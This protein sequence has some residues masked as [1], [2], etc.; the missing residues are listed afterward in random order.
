MLFHNVYYSGPRSYFTYT[1]AD[2][3]HRSNIVVGLS[4]S[5][6]SAFAF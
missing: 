3:V 2:D 4:F 5:R 1:L 6:R